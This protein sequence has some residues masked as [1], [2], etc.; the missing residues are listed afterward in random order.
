M[1]KPVE[2]L[3]RKAARYARDSFEEH[4]EQIFRALQVIEQIA[5]LYGKICRTFF[6]SVFGDVAEYTRKDAVEQCVAETDVPLKE[7]LVH[8]LCKESDEEL[9]GDCMNE[10]IM[11]W[12][13]DNKYEGYEWYIACLYLTG[14]Q[15]FDT[16]LVDWGIGTE[17]FYRTFRA[18]VPE[19]W[20]GEYDRYCRPWIE[21]HR[22]E[23]LSGNLERLNDRFEEERSVK[24]AFHR[25]FGDM[26]PGRIG[27]I[28]GEL[29]Y[30]TLAAGTAYAEEPVRNRFLENMS[31]RQRELVVDEWMHNRGHQYHLNDAF[32]AMDAILIAAGLTGKE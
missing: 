1:D 3:K 12:V 29:D 23:T 32:E 5:C 25:I 30:K 7:L 13:D 16:Y 17:R 21:N 28:M 19:E 31:L 15:Y 8:L 26:E 4:K 14:V 18:M 22:K 9:Y 11:T 6:S 2:I 20:Q 24:T 10:E 27:Y